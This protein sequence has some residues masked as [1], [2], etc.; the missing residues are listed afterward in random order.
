MPLELFLDAQTHALLERLRSDRPLGS[1]EPLF[2]ALEADR[3]R[4]ES[5]FRAFGYELVRDDGGAVALV[6]RSCSTAN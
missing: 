4:Y 6:E 5:L 2:R 1:D 3:A